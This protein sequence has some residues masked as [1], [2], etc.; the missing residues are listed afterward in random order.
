MARDSSLYLQFDVVKER[1]NKTTEAA[2]QEVNDMISGKIE[3]KD[4]HSLEELKK[5]FEN[6]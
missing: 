2:I 6:E 5:G 4:Y 1:Y 3:A